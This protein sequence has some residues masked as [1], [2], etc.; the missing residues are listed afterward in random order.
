VGP[1]ETLDQ[2]QRIFENDNVAVVVDEGQV[3]GIINKIDMLE[4]ITQK[5]RQAA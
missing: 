4:F 5:N 1:N 3:T 2:V